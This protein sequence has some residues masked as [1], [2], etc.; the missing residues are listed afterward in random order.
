MPAC[1][2]EINQKVNALLEAINVNGAYL[3][4]PREVN[5]LFQAG[6]LVVTISFSGEFKADVSFDATLSLAPAITG[7]CASA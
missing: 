6:Q 3:Q 5:V 7:R 4:A 2:E 1:D